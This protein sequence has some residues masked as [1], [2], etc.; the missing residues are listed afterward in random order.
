MNL[1]PA[2]D[3]AFAHPGYET[4]IFKHRHVAGVAKTG[5]VRHVSTKRT[6]NM[7]ASQRDL[8]EMPRD[9]CY[10]NSASYSPLPLRTLEAGR[11][12]VGRK[13]APWTIDAAF[14]PQQ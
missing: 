12:A 7:L 10:L 1:T 5:H 14:A 3:F 8:F 13:G 9:I 4:S 11:A 6:F 2:P